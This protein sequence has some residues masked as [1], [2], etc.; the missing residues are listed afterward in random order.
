MGRRLETLAPTADAVEAA[1]G[2]GIPIVCDQ[3]DDSQVDSAFGRITG[4]AKRLDIMVNNAMGVV[5]YELMFSDAA[6]WTYGPEVWDELID[7]GLRSHLV[8]AQQAARTMVGQRSGLI[9]NISSAGAK[10]R[11]AILPYS[12]GKTALDRMTAEMAADIEPY[13]VTVVSLWPPPTATERMHESAGPDDDPGTW[14]MPV[15][16]G[17]LIAALAVLPDLHSRSGSVLVA[18]ELAKELGIEDPREQRR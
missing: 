14:S 11:F 16:N 4:E 13:G 3:R 5:A 15:F 17:R 12:V 9:V 8:A 6:F 10:R 18:R 1:G 2:V 7:V